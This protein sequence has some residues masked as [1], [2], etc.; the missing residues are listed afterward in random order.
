MK[1]YQVN[2]C[3]N[4]IDK[5][6]NFHW[7]EESMQV[8]E[9]T[10]ALSFQPT[11]QNTQNCTK[12]LL[13]L[14]TVFNTAPSMHIKH[15]FLAASWSPLPYSVTYS[16]ILCRSPTERETHNTDCWQNLNCN[17]NKQKPLITGMF[18]GVTITQSRWRNPS[19]QDMGIDRIV[20]CV[21]IFVYCSSTGP[22]DW[23]RVML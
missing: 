7:Q 11:V 5:E 16:E 15:V 9:I 6:R 19:Q 8:K 2:L 21:H 18:Y 20:I 12:C 22:L 1:S 17:L 4:N 14:G 10:A 13:W 23:R 3:Q